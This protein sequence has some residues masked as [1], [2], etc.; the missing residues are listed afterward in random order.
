MKVAELEIGATPPAESLRRRETLVSPYT[1]LVHAVH[2]SLASPDDGRFATAACELAATEAIL[3]HAL[4]ASAGGAG[5]TFDQARAAA[6]GE[7]AERY[8]AS[9]LPAHKLVLA[10]AQELGEAAVD[11]GRFSLFADEQYAAPG[12]A[13][14]PFR[15]STRVRWIEGVALPAREPAWLPAQLVFLTALPPAPGEELIGY[16]TSNGLACAST[17]EEAILTGLLELLERD[18]F[19]LTWANRLSL[20]RLDVPGADPLLAT[21][22]SRYLEPTGLRYDVVDLSVFH[23]VPTALALLHGAGEGDPVALAVGAASAPLSRDAC[24]K[25]VTEAFVVRTWARSLRLSTPNRSFKDDF[26]DVTTFADH[27]HL[28]ALPAYAGRALFLAASPVLRDASDAP[29]LEGGEPETLLVA[30]LERLE[31]IGASAYAVDVT[32]ADVAAAGLRVAKV[33]VPELCPLDVAH[34]VRFLGGR[35]LYEAAW[36]LGLRETVVGIEDLNH[37]PHPFP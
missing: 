4:D 36:R 13:P 34:G 26:S 21:Y 31:K 3:G 9:H 7:A 19:V 14:R 10:T 6:I 24:R 8:S 25:A 23:M 20:P 12:F 37:D 17:F 16:A 1:G 18:A 33:V 22:H 30:L 29:R 32:A 35:R 15:P 5:G 2:A 28:Y 27:V 11:P